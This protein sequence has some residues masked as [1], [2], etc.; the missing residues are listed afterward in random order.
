MPAI[1]L[2]KFVKN[3]NRKII[4]ANA[5]F[6]VAS[7]AEKRIM[8]AKDVLAQLAS[9]KIRPASGV[10]LAGA[11]NSTVATLPCIE[12]V[13]T[14]FLNDDEAYR[15]QKKAE[16]NN[17]KTRKVIA[18]IGEVQVCDVLAEMKSCDA[19]AIGGLFACAVKFND[20]LK[21]K[22]LDNFSEGQKC[23][24]D[25]CFDDIHVYL[26]KFFTKFQLQM[27]EIAFEQGEG[28]FLILE[29]Y[30][31]WC[32]Y[33]AGRRIYSV[34]NGK[35][36]KKVTFRDKIIVWSDTGGKVAVKH[37]DAFFFTLKER[38][39]KKR[40]EMIMKN[41]VANNGTFIPPADPRSRK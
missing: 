40:M 30:Y 9:K 31:D 7:K 25:F 11:N 16:E 29:D 38:A 21:I 15:I 36:K 33:P 17:E 28:G 4:K 12:K 20:K 27:I 35:K 10:W 39:V 3:H 24:N 14:W 22:E 8:I 23:I 19:C 32:E 37:K 13:E 6:A 41:I 34:F 18:E 26:S 1:N 2:E 5:K